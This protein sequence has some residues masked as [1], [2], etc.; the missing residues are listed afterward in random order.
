VL[1]HARTLPPRRLPN[2]EWIGYADLVVNR[3]EE[4]ST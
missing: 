2:G 4:D 1:D 3:V